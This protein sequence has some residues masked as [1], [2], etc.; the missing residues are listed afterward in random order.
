MLGSGRLRRIMN[1]EDSG[2]DTTDKRYQIM[3]ELEHALQRQKLRMPVTG[4]EESIGDTGDFEGA[5]VNTDLV[6]TVLEEDT[7]NGDTMDLPAVSVGDAVSLLMYQEAR[8]VGFDV[9]K[10]QT[11]FWFGDLEAAGGEYITIEID[12]DFDIYNDFRLK[13]DGEVVKFVEL[14]SSE[15]KFFDVSRSFLLDYFGGSYDTA[16][17]NGRDMSVA[18]E[19]LRLGFIFEEFPFLIKSN[20]SISD[21]QVLKHMMTYQELA[22]VLKMDDNFLRDMRVGMSEI[23]LTR[24]V[25]ELVDKSGFKSYYIVGV[26]RDIEGFATTLLPIFAYGRYKVA[27]IN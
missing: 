25:G 24:T 3:G 8:A 16:L 20:D 13:Y 2:S 10:N 21:L 23:V 27:I 26:K 22:S 14:D 9:V 11:A 7:E 1:P 19:T 4:E 15:S 17:V 18:D 5:R 6:N 12:S